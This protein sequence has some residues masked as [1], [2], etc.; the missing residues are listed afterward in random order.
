[1][2]MAE[3]QY[4]P[5]P[6]ALKKNPFPG[7]SLPIAGVTSGLLSSGMNYPH[8]T[9]NPPGWEGQP[10]PSPLQQWMGTPEGFFAKKRRGRGRGTGAGAGRGA[11]RGRGRRGGGA[12]GG[13]F[14]GGCGDAS[15]ALPGQLDEF[16]DEGV[17]EADELNAEAEEEGLGI[18]MPVRICPWAERDSELLHVFVGLRL[19]GDVVNVESVPEHAGEEEFLF[20]VRCLCSRWAP[21]LPAAGEVAEWCEVACVMGCGA[22]VS[23]KGLREELEAHEKE[24]ETEKQRLQEKAVQHAS[25]QECLQRQMLGSSTSTAADLAAE[26]ELRRQQQAEALEKQKERLVREHQDEVAAQ[27]KAREAEL[28]RQLALRSEQAEREASQRRELEEAAKAQV[29]QQLAEAQA[30]ADAEVLR[31]RAEVEAARQELQALHGQVDPMRAEHRQA[32]DLLR[33]AR[34]ALQAEQEE[35]MSGREVAAL[36]QRL[37]EAHSEHERAQQRHGDVATHLKAQVRDL[38][39]ELQAQQKELHQREQMVAHRDQELAEV[40]GQL[41]DLQG[42]FDEVNGQL[43]RESGRIEGL[44]GA[45]AQCAKQTKELES[46]QKMLEESHQMLAQLKET[47]QI[48]WVT[49]KLQGLTPETLLSRLERDPS[50]L[51]ASS[52]GRFSPA[53]PMAPV[54]PGTATG[55]ATTGRL[56]SFSSVSNVPVSAMA[57]EAIEANRKQLRSSNHPNEARGTRKCLRKGLERRP[58]SDDHPFSLAQR[59]AGVPEYTER[60]KLDR[61]PFSSSFPKLSMSRSLPD[62]KAVQPFKVPLGTGPLTYSPELKQLRSTGFFMKMP[63]L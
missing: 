3:V 28:S 10:P 54:V 25:V 35:R 43:L 12:G 49:G 26:L 17:D 41:V 24:L 42:L 22:N 27:L 16:A 36:E 39:E 13:G 37:A 5:P 53:T 32:V 8:L 48:G 40:N 19:I 2:A 11:A 60:P 52:R 20:T 14:A 15:G 18:G 7:S 62:F 47:S 45:V 59:K 63:P 34:R 58:A 1:M 31:H 50:D 29:A 61:P 55:M 44:Q 56:E 51:R 30:K 6:P 23:K 46:L 38:Q 33:E 4:Y 21:V 57:Q 9:Y